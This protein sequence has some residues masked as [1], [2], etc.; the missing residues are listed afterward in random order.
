MRDVR[1]ATVNGG[2]I[3]SGGSQTDADPVRLTPEQVRQLQ[4]EFEERLRQAQG[5]IPDL[6]EDRELA[7]EMEGLLA[8]MR[9]L[10]GAGLGVSPAALMQLSREVLE[11]LRQFELALSRRLNEVSAKNKLSRPSEDD[12]P[13]GYRKMVDEYFKKIAVK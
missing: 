2:G 1:Q 3:P 7:S 4:K 6:R 8:R 12:V 9:G 5:I 11:P 10:N 13:A